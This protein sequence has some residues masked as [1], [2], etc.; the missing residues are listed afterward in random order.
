MAR[1][2]IKDLDKQ[3]DS[4]VTEV[5]VFRV[6]YATPSRLL[7]MLQSVFTEGPSVPGTEGLNNYVS[8]LQTRREGGKAVSTEQAKT[9]GRHSSA[10]APGPGARWLKTW[11]ATT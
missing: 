7:P 4:A 1:K 5:K 8:R 3:W 6:K 9:V 10:P 11:P 2:L